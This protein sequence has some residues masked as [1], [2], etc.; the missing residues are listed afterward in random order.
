[1]EEHIWGS[2]GLTEIVVGQ[3]RVDQVMIE[4]GSDKGVDDWVI[5]IDIWNEQL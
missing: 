2:Q 3:M 5:V 1:M 4:D